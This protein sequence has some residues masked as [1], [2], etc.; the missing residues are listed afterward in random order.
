MKKWKIIR[1]IT[2]IILVL[3]SIYITIDAIN[4]MNMSYPHPMLGIDAYKWTDQFFMDLYFIAIIG[5]IPLLIDTTLL[6]ISCK[7]IKGNRKKDM[8][9][10]EK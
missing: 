3:A 7:K 8:N 6:I 2:I 5:V 9:E 10:K 1:I 4:C